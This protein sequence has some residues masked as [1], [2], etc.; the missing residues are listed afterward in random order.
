MLIATNS[1]LLEDYSAFLMEFSAIYA[2]MEHIT[3]IRTK[4]RFIIQTGSARDF[5]SCFSTICTG[6]G[7]L[8]DSTR[9]NL[10]L[11]KLK[12]ELQTGLDYYAT[13]QKLPFATLVQHALCIDKSQHKEHKA[14]SENKGAKPGKSSFSQ[15][16]P[17]FISSKSKISNFSKKT[18][19]KPH[20]PLSAAEKQ[21]HRGN[22]LCFYC[23][24][25]EHTFENCPVK[26]AKEQAQET[27]TT[28]YKVNVSSVIIDS[29]NSYP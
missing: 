10:F 26:K 16:N 22:N 9:T 12:P 7:I 29:E 8:D 19:F 4:L 15:A 24:S 11:A 27:F 1:P 2:D 3:D 23:G 20:G 5:A 25:A 6:L 14:K 18:I 21:W 17:P 13:Q 28:S